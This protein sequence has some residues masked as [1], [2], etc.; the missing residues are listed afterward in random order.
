MIRTPLTAVAL[1][2]EITP[3]TFD[4]ASNSRSAIAGHL[5][6]IGFALA[7]CAACARHDETAPLSN[8]AAVP[9]SLSIV[10]GNNQDALAGTILPDRVAFKLTDEA[11]IGIPNRTVAIHVVAGEGTLSPGIDSVST[12]VAGVATAPPW[13]LGHV[14]VLQQ[15]TASIGALSA[16]ASATVT[17]QY[18]A[19]L[20]FFGPPISS[21]YAVVFARAIARLNAE[22]V[23]QLTPVN[24]TNQNVAKDCDAAGVAP[25]TE[26]IGSVVI[27]AAVDSMDGPGGI[28]ASSGPCYVR[29]SNKLTLVGTMLFDSADVPI[30]ANNH[31]LDDVVFH[32]MQHV[33]GFG[34]LW[35]A[36]SP[37][38]SING[39]TPQTAFIG[40]AAILACQ[41][42][43]GVASDCVPSIPLE[44][45]GGPASAD[46]HWRHSIF[47]NELMT[48]SLAPAG[49]SKP[50][51]AMTIGSLADLGYQVNANV[52]DPYSIPSSVAASMANLRAS[53]RIETP[54]IIDRII[55]PRFVV[56]ADGRS[57]RIP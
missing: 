35:T 52:A 36:V 10:A 4:T 12:D 16:T 38:L 49:Q 24:L 32:E 19:Q 53:Q 14:A 26:T 44:N 29:Q 9:S 30:A 45:L 56:S 57:S 25:I 7:M 54:V 18:H 6:P 27:Y 51:S 55:V 39:G 17:T 3:S 2:I 46:S 21:A 1:V 11:G 42:A 40:E 5:L 34:T 31:Q 23:G 48:S 50:L 41:Q 28:V 20:R 15:L 37:A 8:A 47:G 22:I 33:L 13:T 43:H